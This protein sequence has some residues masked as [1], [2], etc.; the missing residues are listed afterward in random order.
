[1][2]CTCLDG[3]C[4]QGFAFAPGEPLPLF[5]RPPQ[6]LAAPE[7]ETLF[8]E[9]LRLPLA[10]L[11]D[12]GEQ[13]ELSWSASSSDPSVAKVRVV[14]GL[15]LIDPEPGVEGA[16]TVEV[17]ATDSHGQTATVRF[18]VQVDFHWPASPFRG[19]RSAVLPD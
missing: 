19:W 7:P 1:M 14:A 3:P 15:L 10:T 13:G 5:A 18:A 4:W 12:P 8:G 6:P 9:S 16:V 17:T 2:G 11:V